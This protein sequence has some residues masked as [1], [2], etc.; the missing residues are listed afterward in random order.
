MSGTSWDQFLNTVRNKLGHKVQASLRA[1]RDIAVSEN[2]VAFAF[3]TNQFSHDMIGAPETMSKVVDLLSGYLGR[4]VRLE[5]QMGDTARLTGLLSLQRQA[6]QEG[7]DPLVEYAVTN[8][9]ASVV[10]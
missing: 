9:R 3:G 5:C 6:E 1:V 2:R 4:S 7:P 8:L 10:E